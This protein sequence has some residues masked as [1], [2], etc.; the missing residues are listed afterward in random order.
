MREPQRINH[1]LKDGKMITRIWHGKTKASDT[2]RYLKYI[3]ETGL[4]DYRATAGNI[5][6][7]ILRRVENDVCHFLTVTEWKDLHSIK[8]FAGNDFEKA[9]Y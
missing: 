2:N 8:I 9:R 5:S 6:A 3:Q 1:N 4:K 7:K